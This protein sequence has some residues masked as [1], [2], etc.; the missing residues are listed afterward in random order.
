M[1]NLQLSHSYRIIYIS[2]MYYG[3]HF[4]LWRSCVQGDF[5]GG[6][7]L[8]WLPLTKK[9]EFS[10]VKPNP[11]V[12]NIDCVQCGVE[13]YHFHVQQ[14][15]GFMFLYSSYHLF[16][17]PLILETLNDYNMQRGSN[18]NQQT[19]SHNSRPRGHGLEAVNGHHYKKKH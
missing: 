7:A 14:V 16:L 19:M 3:F 11:F 15:L 18:S 13:I 12:M 4:L 17:E 9:I 1:K 10:Y 5:I 8:T 6:H 2:C